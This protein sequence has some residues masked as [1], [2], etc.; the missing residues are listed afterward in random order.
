MHVL[1]SKGSSPDD[2]CGEA[3]TCNDRRATS[4]RKGKAPGQK[5]EE[6][7]DRGLLVVTTAFA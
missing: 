4:A 7:S 2:L 5:A 3:T 1:S 6:V